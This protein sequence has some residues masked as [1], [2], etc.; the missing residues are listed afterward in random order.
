MRSDADETQGGWGG[1]GV[2]KARNAKKFITKIA[3]VEPAA[4][5]DAAFSNVII[6]EKKDKRAAKYQL[7]DLPFP[8]T[9]PA[10][11]EQRLRTPLGPEWSTATILRDQT[12]P[13][14]LI[15]PGVTIRPL[16]H[17]DA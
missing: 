4:R 14:I 7:K 1:K 11:Y 5:K 13:K 15:K 17:R 2:K 9:S 8:Y 6:S 12:L 16:G 3:G 10:Q